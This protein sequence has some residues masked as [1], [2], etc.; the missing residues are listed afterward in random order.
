MIEN[1]II[2]IFDFIV[3]A[4]TRQKQKGE[5]WRGVLEDKRSTGG[6]LVARKKFRL[7]FRTESGKRRKIRVGEADFA[8]FEKGRNY[9]KNRGE[10]LPD[11][12]S[13]I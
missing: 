4:L 7:Y 11:P 3:F 5:E 9:Q 2:E 10:M 12:N 13:A 8:L 6:Y 1:I